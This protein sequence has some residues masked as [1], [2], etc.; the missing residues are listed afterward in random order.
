MPLTATQY[1]QMIT[2]QVKDVQVGTPP[3]WVL[4]PQID[5]LWEMHS[6]KAAL[7]HLQFLHAKM[8][9][10]RIV[11]AAIRDTAIDARDGDGG[12]ATEE[13]SQAFDH[14]LDM[15]NDTR[16]EIETYTATI[17]AQTVA[18]QVRAGNGARAALGNIRATLPGPPRWK[19]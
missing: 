18:G 17:A 2:D 7:P 8:E 12:Q 11:L 15:L 5:T 6:D 14:L 16:R 9:A 1:K 3:A 10:I 19:G 4:A 13:H